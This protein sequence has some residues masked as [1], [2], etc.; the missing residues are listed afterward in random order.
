VLFQDANPCALRRSQ[1]VSSP[2]NGNLK[3]LLGVRITLIKERIG[4][5]KA[6]A[7]R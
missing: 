2:V 1:K 6:K 7:Q 5:E 4:E 3:E